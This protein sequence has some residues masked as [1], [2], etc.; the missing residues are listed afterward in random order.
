ML[1]ARR[2][3]SAGAPGRAGMDLTQDLTQMRQTGRHHE[4]RDPASRATAPS[5]GRHTRSAIVCIGYHRV[6]K[7]GPD[8][9]DGA[10]ASAA[11]DAKRAARAGAR[12]RR[13]P[14]RRVN[15]EPRREHR[16]AEGLHGSA[17][18]DMLVRRPRVGRARSAP[19]TCDDRRSR[20][21]AADPQRKLLTSRAERAAGSSQCEWAIRPSSKARRVRVQWYRAVAR[22][23]RPSGRHWPQHRGERALRA[24]AP[25]RARHPA[26]PLSPLAAPA[27]GSSAVPTAVVES[28]RA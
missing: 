28:S 6:N 24:R 17:D 20:A 3:R 16:A 7:V 12:R 11:S 13:A 26:P 22:R 23:V 5:E 25:S 4:A 1:D 2:G 14:S 19:P 15:I 27:A 21:P 8:S 10:R 18:A 9:S